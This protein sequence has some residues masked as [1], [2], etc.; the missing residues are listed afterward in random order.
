MSEKKQKYRT[1]PI[2]KVKRAVARYNMK[3]AGMTHL[4]DPEDS[5][6]SKRSK[7]AIHWR[8]YSDLKE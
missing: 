1:I 8:E 7:F 4:N 3:E 5:S 6:Q 2:R